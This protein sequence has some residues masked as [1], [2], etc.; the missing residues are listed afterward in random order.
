[1]GEIDS[2]RKMKDYSKKFAQLRRDLDTAIGLDT[3]K[4]V[5]DISASKTYCSSVHQ[6]DVFVIQSCGNS[7][8]CCWSPL[9]QKR[10]TCQSARGASR[11]PD[12]N[13]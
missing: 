5:H 7:L 3:K 6:S 11:G 9:R 12:W 8:K 4:D 10:R 1:M 13:T 2:T